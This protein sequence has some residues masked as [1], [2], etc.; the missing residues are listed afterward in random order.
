MAGQ[1]GEP[2]TTA[3]LQ[4][5]MVNMFT[6]GMILRLMFVNPTANLVPVIAYCTAGIHGVMEESS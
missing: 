5:P 4:Y 2:A 1:G 3:G 6:G